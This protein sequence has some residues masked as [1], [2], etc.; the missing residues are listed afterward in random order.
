MQR[1]ASRLAV[2]AVVLSALPLLVYAA[3][4]GAIAVSPDDLRW[5]VAGVSFVPWTAS[6]L[7]SLVLV[8]VSTVVLVRA[9]ARRRSSRGRLLA[10]VATAMSLVGAACGT[11]PLVLLV[12]G[13]AAGIA[14]LVTMVAAAGP[15]G[16]PLGPVAAGWHLLLASEDRIWRARAEDEARS[17]HAFDAIAEVLAA[18]GAPADLVDRVHVASADEDRHAV[19]TAELAGIGTPRPLRTDAR[20]S[21]LPTLMVDT[22]VDGCLGE[23]FAAAVLALEAEEGAQGEVL[24][25]IAADEAGHAALGWDL[26]RWGV[27]QPGVREAL[28]AARLPR[29]SLTP[30]R[31]IGPWRQLALHRTVRRAVVA[32]RDA[33]LAPEPRPV[34]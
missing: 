7:L 20:P 13:V 24:A 29:V 34:G 5:T 8:V 16:R 18:H 3:C 6:T 2:I 28:A 30:S 4:I 27:D 11:T 14:I 32:R 9:V 33:L 21:D 25:S 31:R 19:L 1:P 26:L 22:L 15:M 10:V 12:A 17:V 23:A